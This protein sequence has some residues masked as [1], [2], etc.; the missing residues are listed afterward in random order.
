MSA[1]RMKR[2]TETGMSKKLKEKRTKT[3]RQKQAGIFRENTKAQHQQGE[4]VQRLIAGSLK[5]GYW[6]V[7]DT[8]GNSKCRFQKFGVNQTKSF[9]I[10][11][12]ALIQLWKTEH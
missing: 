10:F 12:T 4:S 6:L 2:R 5:L 9:T 7:G 8:R 11:N 1:E 3:N